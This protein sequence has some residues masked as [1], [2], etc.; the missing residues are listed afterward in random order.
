MS[1]QLFVVSLQ[2]AALQARCQ[3]L[4]L[5][6]KLSSTFTVNDVTSQHSCAESGYDLAE[7]GNCC[8]IRH[9]NQLPRA[10]N[11]WVHASLAL[12]MLCVT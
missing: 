5:S 8:S 4:L 3:H 11:D 12:S 6:L 2:T 1:S 9:V 7:A 10:C